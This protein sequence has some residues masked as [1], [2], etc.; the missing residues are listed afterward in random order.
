NIDVSNNLS[1]NQG[2]VE[3]LFQNFL[4][5]TATTTDLNPWVNQTTAGAD[6]RLSVVTG[7][8]QSDEA[9]GKLVE[10]FYIK[11]L[12]RVADDTGKAYWVSKI[13]GGDDLE[14]IQ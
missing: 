9:L 6:G 2:F 12:G 5:R 10:S 13:K 1:E 11:Y 7:L 3:S 4:G 8:T 14:T